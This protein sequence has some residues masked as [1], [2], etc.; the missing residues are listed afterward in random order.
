MVTNDLEAAFAQISAD[1]SQQYILSYYPADDRGDGRFRTISVRVATRANMRVR[2]RRG[3][4]PRRPNDRF[5]NNAQPAGL[6]EPVI[7]QN[8]A[9]MQTRAVQIAPA[10]TDILPAL[11]SSNISTP[12]KNG[13]SAPLRSRRKGPTDSGDDPAETSSNVKAASAAE[14]EPVIKGGAV[15]TIA[16]EPTT[17]P[18]KPVASPTPTPSP[19]APP[20]SA[21]S[22]AA[23]KSTPPASETAKTSQSQTAK[24]IRD[25]PFNAGVI[26]GKAISLPKPQYPSNARTMRAEGLVTVEVLLDEEGKVLS[27]KAVDGNVALRQAAINAA[28]LAR[29][30]PTLL[31]GQPVK[32]TGVITYKFTLA[33]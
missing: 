25:I 31:A 3:Y 6:S 22:P 13:D 11:S 7:N 4:Y 12:E 23:S 17:S 9:A 29:F 27:A 2:A 33:Q 26:N 20:S 24:P 14:S 8:S 30:S 15:T 16:S 1:L 19:S 21:A 5:S 32:V 28:R 18:P 10:P